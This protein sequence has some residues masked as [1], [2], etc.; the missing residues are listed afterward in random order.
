MYAGPLALL[1]ARV[2]PDWPA[3]SFDGSD[4]RLERFVSGPIDARE[5]PGAHVDVLDERHT[6]HLAETLRAALES[7]ATGVRSKG[8]GADR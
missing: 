7:H 6:A 5:I 4:A 2:H 1:R 8:A 3:T